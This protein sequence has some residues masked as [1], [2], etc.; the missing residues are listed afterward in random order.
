MPSNISSLFTVVKL[1]GE[2]DELFLAPDQVQVEEKHFAVGATCK[3]YK[4]SLA[5][6]GNFGNIPIALKQS[7][8]PVTRRPWKRSVEKEVGLFKQLHHENVIKFYGR[9]KTRYML[10]YEFMEKGYL[11][12]E[13]RA[14]CMMQGCCW[15]RWKKPFRGIFVST[16]LKVE[17]KD[18]VTY[19][20]K[21]LSTEMLKQPIFCLWRT[22]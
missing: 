22:R 14:L 18:W 8:V 7:T 16:S 17:L 20:Q 6:F 3:M 1:P 15:T 4:G 5:P 9:E 10:A 19:I 2:G 13:K 11:L 21:A 12:M